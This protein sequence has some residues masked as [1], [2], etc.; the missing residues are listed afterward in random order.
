MPLNLLD[1]EFRRDPYP[2]LARARVEE[3]V[4]QD[5][6]GIWYVTRHADVSALNRDA[7]LGRDLRK[8]LAYPMLRPYLADSPLERCVELWMFSLDPPD[9]TRLRKLVA[10]AFTP[11]AVAAMRSS[12]EAAADEILARI[13]REAGP[14]T[15]DL[16][17]TFAHPF[18]VQVIASI[19][20]LSL[21]DSATLRE[22]SDAISFIVEPTARRRHKQ[23]ASD[24]VVGMMSYLRE[25]VAARRT[26][27]ANDVIS[28][29]IRAEEEGDRLTED[30]LL[31]Q[32]VLLFFAGFETTANL[33]GNGM[34][35]L[36][37]HPEELARLR[38]DA[39][40]L[41]TAVEEMLRYE[42]PA[43]NNARVAHTDITV[44]GQTIPAGSLA[45]CML[46]AANRDPEVFAD[47][48]R[49]DAARDPNPHV[50]FGGGIHHCIGAS[51]ARLE[52]QVAFERL[53]ARFESIELDEE[54]VK[55]RDL[56]NIRGL[57][58]LP[59]RVA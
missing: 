10:K 52:A 19:L 6:M 17:T 23:L 11:K 45:L 29:L 57:S 7:R 28:E 46:G 56:V 41:P 35:A 16:V 33:I 21:G 2:A 18:P 13:P 22:W 51:L 44:G 1:P 42:S 15:I 49:F 25:Q 54:G 24:A 8:W 59:V 4:H 30:E 9:H 37:R 38:R 5:P 39:S 32:L 12:I 58:A 34:L 50:A 36:C 27:P 55:W 47:P 48:D 3:P 26:S 31:A 53:L 40:L 14:R 20:G 43:N